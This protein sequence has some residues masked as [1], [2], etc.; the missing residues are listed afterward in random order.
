VERSC[1]APEAPE[2]KAQ[3]GAL[4]SEPPAQR[5]PKLPEPLPLEEPVPPQAASPDAPETD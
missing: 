1:A 2:Q 4:Q 3:P 5:S